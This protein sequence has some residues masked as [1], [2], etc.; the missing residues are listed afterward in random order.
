M[1]SVRIVLCEPMPEPGMRLLQTRKEFELKVLPRPTQ[2]ALATA[3]QEADAIIIVAEQPRLSAQVIAAASRLRLVARMGAGTD[4]F[5]IAAL[6]ARRIPLL[7]TGS[8]NAGAVA[9]HA[10]YLML[11]LAKRGPVRDRAIKAGGWP[12]AFGALELAGQTCLVVGLGRVGRAIARR[13]A[14]FD[15]NVVI[16]DPDVT[17]AKA[18]D[19]GLAL[20][21]SLDAA[22]CDADVVI[23]ACA[24]TQATHG[25]IGEAALARMKPTALLV[26]VARGGVVDEPA[27]ARAL[28]AGR[29]AGAGLDVLA[30][31]PP[32]PDNPLL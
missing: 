17:A 16:V 5:D 1:P 19:L 3:A 15:M 14:A 29:I 23:L 10:I 12:R 30:V 32:A 27:L 18:S 11:A 21:T 25:L 26:N 20:A 13:A 8:A 4:N 6:T 24:L 31:E 22:L 7:T 9:E 2:E 28:A